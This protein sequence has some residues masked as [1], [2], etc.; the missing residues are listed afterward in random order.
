MNKHQLRAFAL[1]DPERF[2]RH[3]RGA[4][5]R[6]LAARHFLLHPDRIASASAA[7][8]EALREYIH[9]RNWRSLYGH[10]RRM[11]R[12]LRAGAEKLRNIPS[13]TP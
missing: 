1:R 5:E 11:Y 9:A 12:L 13:L 4:R 10:D 7:E 6:E 3:I 2:R 8:L